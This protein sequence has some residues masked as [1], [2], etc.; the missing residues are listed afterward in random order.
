MI[1]RIWI[2]SITF[3][4]GTTINLSRSDIVVLVG[5]NNAGKSAALKDIPT[6]LYQ[7]ITDGQV[8]TDI[9]LDKYGKLEEFISWFEKNTTKK[10]SLDPSNPTYSTSSANITHGHI[11][12]VWQ[13]F[14]RGLYDVAK[15]ICSHLTTEDR[16]KAANPAQNI[17]LTKDVLSHPI[18]YMQK[19]DTLEAK[20]SGYFRQAFGVDL[21]VHRNAGSQVPLYCG[22][23]PKFDKGEDRVSESY[24]RKLEEL[25]PLHQQGDGMRAFVGVLLQ[26]LIMDRSITL[27]D[28]PEAFLHPPQARLLGRMLAKEIPTER[29]VFLAT[30]S[31]SFLNGLLDAESKRVKVIRITRTNNVNY[32][33]ELRNEEITELWSNPLLKHSNVLDGLFHEKVIIG[34]SDADCR[35]YGTLADNI[36]DSKRSKVRKDVMF[37]YC[38][39]KDRL[40]TVIKALYSLGVPIAVVADFDVLKEEKLLKLIFEQLG[41]NWDEISKDWKIVK[42]EIEQ[43]KALVENK[44]V[45]EK[46]NKA[47]SEVDPNKTNFPKEK[48]KAI[49]EALKD[50]SP[51]ALAKGSGIH[52][53]PSGQATESAD[54]LFKKLNERGLFVVQ[55]GELECFVRS[56]GGHGPNWVNDVFKKYSAK[57]N[58]LKEAR[59][60][61]SSFIK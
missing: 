36:F 11:L 59:E 38:S 2:S 12:G 13:D 34:E 39:G 45:I 25:P 48:A 58:E 7:R 15:I 10:P 8:I 27:I 18:H 20:I 22:H 54:R 21:I 47:L 53:I 42:Q 40:P 51:W 33:K 46:I 41:G 49:Q 44:E 61:V 31:S 28:E 37:T 52:F 32:V 1:S 55:V 30:H 23:K 5:A 16:L 24:L 17:S 9:T 6:K 4:D 19:T 14:S 43:R 26:T 3:S 29:Q 60:F 56:V 35:F 57:S 50:S